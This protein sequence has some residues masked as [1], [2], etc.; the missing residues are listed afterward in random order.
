MHD[1]D[2][3]EEG[4]V[5]GQPIE[6]YVPVTVEECLAALLSPRTR[7]HARDEVDEALAPFLRELVTLTTADD[8]WPE[9]TRHDL[10]IM[11]GGRESRIPDHEL[12]DLV[13]KHLGDT[14][15]T[16]VERLLAANYRTWLELDFAK[17]KSKYEKAL[18]I[19]R[20]VGG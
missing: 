8:V 11:I 13:D 1:Y 17:R 5:A 12:R 6:G 7:Q 14:P 16:A 9:L 3:L 20:A 19:V 18:S 10:R 4:I 2:D 15:L